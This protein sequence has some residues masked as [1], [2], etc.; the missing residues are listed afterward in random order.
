MVKIEGAC[1]QDAAALGFVAGTQRVDVAQVVTAPDAAYVVLELGMVRASELAI[2]AVRGEGEGKVVAMTRSETRAAPVVKATLEIP[3]F[4]PIDFIPNNRR[5]IVHGPHLTG[6]ELALISVPDVYDA[7]VDQ[8]GMTFIR[9]D[10]NAAGLVALQFGYRIPTLPHPLDTENLAVLTD[11]LQRGVK[12][13]T[14]PR[15]SG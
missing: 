15:L 5:A 6:A 13:R 14:S 10:M 4:P 11:A 2:E 12:K 7:T 1:M 8:G 9:G 3:G